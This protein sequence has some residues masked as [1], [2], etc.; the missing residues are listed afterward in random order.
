M[1]LARFEG[2]GGFAGGRGGTGGLWADDVSISDRSASKKAVSSFDTDG[3]IAGESE[4][5]QAEFDFDI[6]SL[7]LDTNQGPFR[8]FQS[9]FRRVENIS[10]IE[11]GQSLE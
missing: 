11:A 2:G 5:G 1:L 4:R 10:S 9:I 3:G 8:L 6:A 7:P